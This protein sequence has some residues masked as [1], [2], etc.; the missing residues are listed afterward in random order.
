MMWVAMIV[1]AVVGSVINSLVWRLPRNLNWVKGRSVCPKCKH[2]L[3]VWDL[4]PILS[5]LF[6]K[7]RCRYCTKPIG[8]RYLVVE[9]ALAISFGV[10][11][12]SGIS[13]L[14]ILLASILSVSIV[15]AVMDWETMLVSEALVLLWGILVS[16]HQYLTGGNGLNLL[17]AVAIAVG[18]I[19]GLWLLTRGR[20]MG[21]GDVE[22]AAVMGLMV[23]WPNILVALWVAFV[24]GALV[25]VSF[26]LT[27]KSQFN[28]QIAFGPFLILGTW[29]AY[30][31]GGTIISWL[32]FQF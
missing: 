4:F 5:F 20:A 21:F 6:L 11:F 26:L 10:I 19:G 16:I 12:S 14:T 27:K 1:G 31:A 8:I 17:V 24:T 15:V 28:S 22:I 32:N 23:G 3:Q 25:G 2:E 9:L 18:V 30:L 29:V 7:G 13:L